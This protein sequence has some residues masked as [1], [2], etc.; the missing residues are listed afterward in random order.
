MESERDL[1]TA[2]CKLSCSSLIIACKTISNIHTWVHVTWPLKRAKLIIQWGHVIL[3]SRYLEFSIISTLDCIT[4]H[5]LV[6]VYNFTLDI[7]KPRYLELRPH[8]QTSTCVIVSQI[9]FSGDLE[10]QISRT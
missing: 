3:N 8:P 9:F 4:G 2:S 7:L 6:S 5:R 1:K 10:T